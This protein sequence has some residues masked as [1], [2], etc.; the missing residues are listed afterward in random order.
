MH[1]LS[2]PEVSKTYDRQS[3]TRLLT[4]GGFPEP[5]LKQ[6]ATFLRKWHR[7]RRERVV[8]TDIRDLENVKDISRIELLV[9]SL[10]DRV[11]SPLSR[12]NLAE[13]LEAD[14]KTI[15]RRISILEHVYYCFRIAQGQS[16]FT[17]SSRVRILPFSEFC[18]VAELK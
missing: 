4:Y 13:D 5:F 9:T 1:P 3:F 14:F 16:S 6:D 18:Q 11:G 12:K 10:L 15:E 8:Y 7:Q 2:L 17:T